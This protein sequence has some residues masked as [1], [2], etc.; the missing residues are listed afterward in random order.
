[1]VVRTVPKQVK[2]DVIQKYPLKE[3]DVI[4]LGKLKIKVR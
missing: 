3:R 2:F 4:K 1:M